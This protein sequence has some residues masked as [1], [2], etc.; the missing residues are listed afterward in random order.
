MSTIR[1]MTNITS[2]SVVQVTFD[3]AAV[4]AATTAEQDITVTGVQVGDMVLGINKP[5]VTAG[6]GIAGARVKSAN[7]ISVT[8]VNAT[9]GSVNPAS[10]VYTIVLA[11]PAGTL[12]AVARL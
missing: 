3:P 12:D 4:S 8:F 5:T 7:T 10:E 1:P 11:R 9:A 6:V 2:I